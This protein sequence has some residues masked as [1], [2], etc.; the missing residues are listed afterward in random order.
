M[1][2]PACIRGVLGVIADPALKEGEYLLLQKPFFL[3]RQLRRSPIRASSCHSLKS[4]SGKDLITPQSNSFAA[5][6]ITAHVYNLLRKFSQFSLSGLQV[7]E[8]ILSNSIEKQNN[9]KTKFDFTK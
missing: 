4:E 1:S 8:M 3:L 7:Y 9:E 2:S 6:T 5:P